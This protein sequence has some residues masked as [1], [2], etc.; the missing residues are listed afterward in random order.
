M[1]VDWKLLENLMFRT[2]Y[3]YWQPGE[4]FSY[5]YQAWGH[6][7]GFSGSDRWRGRKGAFPDQRASG[8]LT[9]NFLEEISIE[10]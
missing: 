5:A 1:G 10:N 4:W 8:I 9:G 2:R 3:S 7:P 6:L